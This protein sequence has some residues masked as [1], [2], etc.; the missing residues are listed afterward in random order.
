MSPYLT[1]YG[2]DMRMPES[3]FTWF[4]HNFVDHDGAKCPPWNLTE[5]STAGGL[6]PHPVYPSLLRTQ[7]LPQHLQ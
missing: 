1:H 5:T 7:A 3:N 4:K 2:W 6:F